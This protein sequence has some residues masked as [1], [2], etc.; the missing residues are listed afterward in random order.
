QARCQCGHSASPRTASENVP[1][2]VDAAAGRLG[3]ARSPATGGA[4]G[5]MTVRSELGWARRMWLVFGDGR[6]LCRP[7][8][9]PV[10]RRDETRVI[11][12]GK[13][14]TPARFGTEGSVV[15]IPS[16]RPIL[17]KS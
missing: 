6:S 16:P 10:G 15:Q 14:D 3:F 9:Y 13:L 11:L 12:F 5:V 4:A 7:N 2:T 1:A 17:R 8:S